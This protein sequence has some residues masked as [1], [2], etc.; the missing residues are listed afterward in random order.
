MYSN[1]ESRSMD[2][3]FSVERHS[4]HDPVNCSTSLRKQTIDGF[5]QSVIE[6]ADS[7]SQVKNKAHIQTAD[8]CGHLSKIKKQLSDPHLSGKNI[9]FPKSVNQSSDFHS[10]V[11]NIASHKTT[12][13]H[14]QYS[15]V[16]PDD[17]MSMENINPPVQKSKPPTQTHTEF[18]QSVIKSADSHSQVKNNEHITPASP[19]VHTTVGFPQSVIESADSHSQVKSNAHIPTTSSTVQTIVGFPQSVIESADSHS[20]VKNNENIQTA[21]RCGHSPKI[22]QQPPDPHLSG[23]NIG[24]P[25]SVNQSSDFTRK[26][27]IQPRKKLQTHAKSTRMSNRTTICRRK[28]LTHILQN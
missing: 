1:P 3:H 2:S 6:S 26:S 10:Q 20:Q 4:Q 5:S 28:I 17:D 14:H 8:Q 27:K 19:I 22:K 18:Q 7:H 24:F 23:K 25:K 15:D 11:K 21:D 13:S 16:E 9:G 12:S